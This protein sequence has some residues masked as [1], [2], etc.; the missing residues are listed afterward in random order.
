MIQAGHYYQLKAVKKV[1]FG[2]YLDAEGLE[3]LLPKRFVPDGLIEGDEIK[4]FIYHDNEDRLIATTQEP[5]ATVGDVALLKCVSKT[6]YGAF[7]EWGIMKDVFVPLSHQLSRMQEGERYIVY[8]F[9]DEMTGRVTATEKF[10]KF[11]SNDEL[12]VKENETVDLL[13]WQQTDIGYKVIINNKHTGVV[14]FSDVFRDLQYGE[15]LKGFIKKIREENKIDVAIGERGY[16]RVS[17]ET[18]RLLQLLRENDGYLPYNDKSS[19]DDIYSF[20]GI[21]KKTFKMSVG[22]LY[23]DRKIELTKTGIKLLE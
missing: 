7:M 4:V 3:I 14:H 9:I 17:P 11:L 18:E 21:S 20:F 1:D 8:L 12:T 15:K 22:A 19:P 13:V 16:E 2:F 5:F 10:Q 23:K 6:D